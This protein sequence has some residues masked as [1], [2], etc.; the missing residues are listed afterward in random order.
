MFGGELAYQISEAGHAIE[1]SDESYQLPK[2]DNYSLVRYTDWATPVYV[3]RSFN[4]YTANC[5]QMKWIWFLTDSTGNDKSPMSFLCSD[6]ARLVIPQS[7]TR[8]R[9]NAARKLMAMKTE[10]RYLPIIFYGLHRPLGLEAT[11]ETP[12]V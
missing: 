9:V 6:T 1:Q 10:A 2:Y 8:Q 3:N 12:V 7:I 5:L 11:A 4:C